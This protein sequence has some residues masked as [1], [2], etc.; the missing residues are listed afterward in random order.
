MAAARDAGVPVPVTYGLVVVDGRPG[1]VMDRVGDGDSPMDQPIRLLLVARELGRLQAQLNEAVAP[2]S[3]PGVRD[4]LRERI[5]VASHLTEALRDGART[6][7]DTLPDGDRLCHGDFHPGNVL[8]GTSG[9]VVIDWPN[10]SRG[11]PCADF[12][13][14]QLL[15]H[16]AALPPGTSA[17][18]TVAD[19]VGRG[20]LRRQWE[21][22][23]RAHRSIDDDAAMRWETVHAAA[24]LAEGIDEE[25]P[26]LL[27]L[28]DQR[29]AGPTS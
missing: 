16:V 18:M 27:G 6:M 11:D 14:T 3:L 9:T 4:V 21:R 10:S 19:R 13:R 17:F 22:G 20:W 8:N 24:R 5:D 7:L 23:Y 15:F 26:A 1:L 12:A 2:P 29:L 28:L 25:T